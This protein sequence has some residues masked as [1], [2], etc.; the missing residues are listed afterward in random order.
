M[1]ND[2]TKAIGRAVRGAG[3]SAGWEERIGPLC[4]V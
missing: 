2:A 1:Q 3:N 4:R